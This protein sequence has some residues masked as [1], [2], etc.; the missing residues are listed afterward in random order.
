MPLYYFHLRGGPVDILAEEGLEYPDEAAARR[1]ALAGV[2][3]M[4][5]ADVA[6]GILDLGSRM[7]V[8]DADGRLLFSIPFSSAVTKR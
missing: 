1:A 4:I 6:D 5:A 3:G 8:T 7:D 2:R